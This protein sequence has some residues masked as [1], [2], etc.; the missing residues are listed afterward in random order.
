MAKFLP[1]GKTASEMVPACSLPLSGASQGNNQT[2]MTK[3]TR[4]HPV[5]FPTLFYKHCKY[6]KSEVA[7]FLNHQHFISKQ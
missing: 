1:V 6:G 5:T 3:R 4:K 2:E 7:Q